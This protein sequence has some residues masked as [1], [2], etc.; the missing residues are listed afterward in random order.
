[1]TTTTANAI[2]GDTLTQALNNPKELNK[3]LSAAGAEITD[4]NELLI[5]DP[6]KN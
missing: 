3:N 5:K 2:M 6:K 1:M 4:D